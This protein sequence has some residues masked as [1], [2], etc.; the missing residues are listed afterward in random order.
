MSERPRRPAA[1][2]LDDDRVIVVSPSAEANARSGFGKVRVTP[3]PEWEAVELPPAM[4]ARKR[5]FP[6]ATVFWSAAS[7]LLLLAFGIAVDRLIADLFSRADWLGTLGLTLAVLAGIA[8]LAIVLRELLGLARLGAIEGLRQRAAD[9]I[10][11]DDRA[12]GHEVV[13]E[14]VALTARMP[15]LA[16]GR[17]RLQ[18]HLA[19]II[20]GRDLIQLA[21]RDLMAPL[22]EEAR[23]LVST[24]AK[25]VSI[26][27]AVSP[28]AAV[29]MLFVF[30]TALGLIRR[31]AAL[32]GG[33]PGTL[34]LVRLLRHVVSHLT[35]TGGMAMGDS[36]I[37]QVISHGVAAKL[38]ARL[39]EGVLNGLLTA[40]LGLAAIE[41]T[42]PLPFA[43]LPKPTLN[44]LAGNLLRGAGNLRDDAASPSDSPKPSRT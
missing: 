40:R 19:E 42:R 12:A 9:I 17:A 39:G 31:L 25:R 41:V 10:V 21:E 36:L 32:Y 33:R 8:L 26:V 1:F 27:T 11:S 15:R 3:E 30:V 34:G 43:A 24:A 37:Q 5:R 44:D 6:W 38:S 13:R 22:D 18:A 14:L 7:G 35:L 28:R 23:R 29:D 4:P 16:Q 20:D 2:S